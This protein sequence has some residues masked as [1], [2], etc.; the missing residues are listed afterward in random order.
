MAFTRTTNVVDAAVVTVALRNNAVI[1]TGDPA[2]MQ[3]LA[4]ASSHGVVIYR[5][6]IPWH[7]KSCTLEL[8]LFWNLDAPPHQRAPL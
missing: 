7:G 3:R 2:G 5:R 4:Q 6:L 8:K 1:L